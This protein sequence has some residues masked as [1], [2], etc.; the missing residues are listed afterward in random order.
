MTTYL[1]RLKGQNFLIDSGEGP[2]KKRFKS[3]RLVEA[4]NK[5][6]AEDLARDLIIND[7]R[8]KNILMNEES[9]PPIIYCES[10]SEISA[11]AY[12]AQR[13][14]HSIYWEDDNSNRRS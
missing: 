4:E 10:V 14:A 5:K 1:V 8:L 12:D 7:P 6:L 3:T 2:K 13:R 11:I 9:N